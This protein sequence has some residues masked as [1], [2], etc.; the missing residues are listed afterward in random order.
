MKKLFTS[1]FAFA[2]TLNF[3]AENI[4]PAQTNISF[5]ENKGQVHDQNYK[6]RPDVLFGGNDGGLVFHL[7]TNG[8][9]YQLSRVDSWKEE[10]D[11]RTKEKRKEINKSTTYRLDINWLNANTNANILKGKA[12]E[13]F[14]NYYSESCPNGAINVQSFEEV[15]YQ[16]I[17]SGI[18]LKWYQ[19]DGHLKYDYL[20]DAGS[21]YKQIQLEI[22][23]AEKIS[24][25][26]KGELVLKT[27]LGTIIENAPLVLQNE[28]KLKAKW[29]IKSNT[30]S[31]E[32]EN[33][34]PQQSF[35]IDPAVRVW[36]T[37]YG[38][39]GYDAAYSTSQDPSGNV[40]LAG[41]AGTIGGTVIATAG[42][43]QTVHNGGVYDA[44]LTKLDVNGIR[45]WGTYYG[46]NGDDY[47]RSCS[48]DPSGN[49]YLAGY[50]SSGTGTVIAN[51]GHQL[52][53]GG[54][55]NDAFLVKFSSAGVRQWGTY[56]GGTGQEQGFGCKTDN[57]GNIYL[58]G[59]TD[60][61]SG[62]VIATP[63][64]H[65][66]A[67]LGSIDGFIVKFNSAGVR[68]WG[69]YYGGAGIDIA[70]SCD[71]DGSGNVY[72]CGETSSGTSTVIANLGSHQNTSGGATDAFLAKFNSSG[73][74]QWGT[75][76][77]GS[78]SDYGYSC[79]TNSV[80]D[81]FLTGY[82]G[83]GTS[84]LIATLGSHQ[85]SASTAP[86]AFLVK[87]N[88][89]GIRQWGT[90][91]GGTGNDYVYNSTTDF[92]GNVYICGYTSSNT[93]T[94]IATVGSY[95]SVFGGNEDS[96]LAMFNSNG[97]RQWGTYYGGT[98]IDRAQ[99]CIIDGIGNIY[100]VGFTASNTGTIV[101][102][103]GSHQPTHGGG[104]FD[105][106]LVKLFECLPPIAP[107]SSTPL[108]NQTICNNNTTNLMVTGSGTVT[109]YATPTSTTAL[110]TGTNY[111]TPSLT[112]GTY[113][114]Y[115]EA[116]TCT[117][118]AS[119]TPITVTVNPSPTITVNSG[120]ICSGNSFTMSPSGANSY[121]F[122]GGNAAVSPTSTSSYTVVGTNTL[123]C[124][125]NI[126][127]SNVTVN[128]NP[129]VTAVSS[130]SL[131]CVGQSATLTA[132]GA[133]TYTFNPGGAGNNI[134]ISPTVT[135]TYTITGTN[136]FGCQ[137]TTSFT[138]SVSACTGI[139][140]VAQALEAG[141]EVYPNPFNNKIAVVANASG[142]HISICNTLGQIVYTAPSPL[143]NAGDE[144][145]IDLNNLASGIYFVK[146]QSKNEFVIKKIIKQ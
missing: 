118:S 65:Q 94:N 42:A 44:F 81:V 69:S 104:T 115:A 122:Q 28:K 50:T 113:T 53:Y 70:R 58:V 68:Q 34:N 49:I 106:F 138:Q 35:I 7:K 8:L 91:Y 117:V 75:Y 13:G 139:N 119:R 41:Y 129:T 79:T 17:Y 37:Y 87:F 95:Q 61:N 9:S 25:N 114:Y 31:F 110:G 145:E 127:T 126:A 99:S 131:L 83:S 55:S 56:Y 143:E 46:G 2:F 134:T 14:N 59:S 1:F 92:L 47:G 26:S 97:V 78:G 54:G 73:V 10:I 62:T 3:S 88:S 45:L 6:P 39:T 128:P 67:L 102:S 84:T 76:Y 66:T 121:T 123:G 132:N 124:N 52:L 20:V 140:M 43:H 105:A 16:N 60:I 96:F 107:N 5:T 142:Q 18:D 120:S 38:G 19:K 82:T 80:G 21:D 72:F 136:T 51:N 48:I 29:I 85:P 101:A 71:V 146:V 89:A 109:W 57:S 100:C 98:G 93:G 111:T 77:G 24:L 64:S 86:D 108:S 135:S 63:G 36:G 74:R 112:V 125:S 137:N 32:I 141:V 133:S 15:T 22:K 27:P 90:F 33:L 103:I 12:Y 116:A 40:Y 144:A 30:L 23:G 130:S 4:T 11:E